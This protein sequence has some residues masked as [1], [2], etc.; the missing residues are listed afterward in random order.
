MASV[1][2][3]NANISFGVRHITGGRAVNL[4]KKQMRAAMQK[5]GGYKQFEARLIKLADQPDM[6]KVA[7]KVSQYPRPQREFI[8]KR[9]IN[10]GPQEP[11]EKALNESILKVF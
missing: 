9:L 11:S 10:K 5:T 7:E 2:K 8:L 3:V 1:N 6:L 4:A